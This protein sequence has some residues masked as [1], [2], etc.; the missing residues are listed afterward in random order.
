MNSTKSKI[1]RVALRMVSEKGYEWLSFQK[2][3]DEVGIAKSSIYH[4]FKKKEDLG[5][6]IMELIKE[7]VQKKQEEILVYKS[8]KEKLDAFLIKANTEETLYYEAIAKL[9]FDF[10]GLPLKL[11]NKIREHSIK[12]HKFV[13]EI[14]KRGT[15]KK[16]FNITKDLEETTTGI[17]LMS[18]GGYIYGR[19]FDDIDLDIGKYITN[20]ITD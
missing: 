11:Q 4:Y 10:N 14:L 16:E 8:E 6:A 18:I 7:R 3:A 9:T 1:I 17:I 5:V 15:E 13:F 12:T 20:S 19:V 2:V